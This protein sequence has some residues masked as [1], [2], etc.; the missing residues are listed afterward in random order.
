MPCPHLVLLMATIGIAMPNVLAARTDAL[1]HPATITVLQMIAE[2]QTDAE[3]LERIDE[4]APFPGFDGRDLAELKRR[5]VSDQILLRMLELTGDDTGSRPPSATMPMGN[6]PLR[7]PTPSRGGLIRVLVDC[8]FDVTYLEV[9]LDGEIKSTKGELWTGSVGSGAHLA[10]PPEVA[11]EKPGVLFELPVPP[12]RHTAA[13]GFAVTKIRQNPSEV[14]G[15]EAG[16]RYVT[17]GIR[18]TSSFLPGQAPSGNPGVVCNVSA[19]QLCEIVAIPQHTSSA[20]LSGAS[21]YDV[22]YQASIVELR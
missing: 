10:S 5:G 12:G 1:E 8:P 7:S 15:E 11:V 21:T 4:L 18:A 16:E 14:W 2:G 9:A 3:I 22:R 17:R 19:G 6:P 13:V 20:L